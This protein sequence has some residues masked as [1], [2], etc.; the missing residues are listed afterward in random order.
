MTLRKRMNSLMPVAL[1]IAADDGAIENVEGG[2]QGGGAVSL[3]VMG[4]RS[5]A[6]RFQG[7]ARLSTVERLDLRLFVDREDLRVLSRSTRQPL[8]P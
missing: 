2:E 8:P 6:A 7:Q 4:H 3:V 5:G 1:H